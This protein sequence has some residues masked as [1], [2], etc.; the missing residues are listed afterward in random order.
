MIK[1]SKHCKYSKMSHL[2]CLDCETVDST[3][4]VSGY[5]HEK[6]SEVKHGVTHR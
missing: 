3:N 2:E 5:N 4:K 1:I 6:Q